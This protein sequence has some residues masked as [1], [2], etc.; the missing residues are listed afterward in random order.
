MSFSKAV[1]S[2]TAPLYLLD[3]HAVYGP[4]LTGLRRCVPHLRDA[5]RVSCPRVDKSMMRC[6]ILTDKTVHWVIFL[7]ML[8]IEFKLLGVY[9]ANICTS[10]SGMV[11]ALLFS[12]Y[13]VYTRADSRLPSPLFV[14]LNSA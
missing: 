11:R 3:M 12:S 5:A 6:N 9:S 8:L 13:E 14:V 10:C 7:D 1:G 2:M 4:R